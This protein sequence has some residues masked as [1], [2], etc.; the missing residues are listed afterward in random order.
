[1]PHGVEILDGPLLADPRQ[2]APAGR[3]RQGEEE[4]FQRLLTRLLAFRLAGPSNN[5]KDNYVSSSP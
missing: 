3:A 2:A 5:L 1:M 4:Q